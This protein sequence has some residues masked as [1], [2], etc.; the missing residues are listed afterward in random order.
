MA[1]ESGDLFQPLACPVNW[2]A[3]QQVGKLLHDL[4]Y[5]V[6]D[7]EG[8][9]SV[10]G[11]N[12]KKIKGDPLIDKYLLFKECQ[13]RVSTYGMSWIK[14]INKHTGRVHSTFWQILDTGRLSSG[15]AK[16]GIPNLLNIPQSNDV[17]NGIVPEKGNV[18]IDSDYTGQENVILAEKS[19]EPNLLAFFKK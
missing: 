11:K 7:N 16:E 8:K 10:E 12:L 18:L 9:I 2:N 17:R 14:A 15:N 3:P 1:I 6:T 5:P 4:G 13:K 19:Q